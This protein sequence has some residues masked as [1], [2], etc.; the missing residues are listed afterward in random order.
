MYDYIVVGGGSAGSALAG[1]L[2]EINDARVL[3][4]EAGP[5]D[6]NPYIHIPV[7]FLKMKGGPLTWG[8]KTAPQSHLNNREIPFA[9]ARVLGGGGSINAEIFT[10]GCPQDYDR[11]AN[12]EGCV[13]WSFADVLP[14]YVVV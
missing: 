3:L 14:Y 4:L 1:R 7:G 13:G 5:V 8:Y 9:Q 2:S 11:W 12:E 6:S 10:R